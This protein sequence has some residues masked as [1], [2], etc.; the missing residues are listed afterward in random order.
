MSKFVLNETSIIFDSDGV[1][2]KVIDIRKNFIDTKIDD[3]KYFLH[4]EPISVN[5]IVKRVFY[6]K[7]K[8]NILHT[9]VPAKTYIAKYIFHTHLTLDFE[10]KLTHR[11]YIFLLSLNNINYSTLKL[12]K[13]IPLTHNN[14][15]IIYNINYFKNIFNN[16]NIKQQYIKDFLKQ[17]PIA[18]NYFIDKISQ[19]K[20]IIPYSSLNHYQTQVPLIQ[21]IS[22][23]FPNSTSLQIALSH[24]QNI[25]LNTI[26]NLYL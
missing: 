11:Q 15:I 24:T 13:I 1:I 5:Y 23:P 19:N 7:Y 26:F 18:S 4:Q 9:H 17:C 25:I 10:I 3:Y 21:H 14:N 8:L 22:Y 6:K 20:S 2:C 12:P 16:V